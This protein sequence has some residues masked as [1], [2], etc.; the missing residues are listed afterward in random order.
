[1]III[2]HSLIILLVSLS[3]LLLAQP[4][5][6]ANDIV[7]E[8]NIPFKL[9]INP[10]FNGHQWS[11]Q[12]S[13]DIAVGNPDV[14][15][16]GVGIQA[17][18]VPLPES[19]LEFWGYDIRVDAF[20]HYA[21]LGLTENVVFLEAPSDDHR[22]TTFYCNG[23]Q[24]TMFANIYEPIWDDGAN[25]TP[26]N[27]D[28]Y[29]A[30]YFYRT[31]SK[32]KD[33]VKFWEIWNEPDLDNSGT[34]WMPP[35][36]P[37]NWYDN[38][39]DPC[40][41]Q[42]RAPVYEYIRLLRIAYEVIKSVDPDAYI[43][44]GG[45][46][47]ESF[48]DVIL[49]FTDNPDGG[50][51][52]PEYPLTGGAYFD[53]LSFHVYPHINGSLKV[54]DNSISGFAYSRHSDAAVEG[55][56]DF[57]NRFQ[58]ILYQYGYD[59]QTYPEK[60][61]ILTE[62]G[63]PRKQFQDHIGSDAAARNYAIKLQIE[64]Y[65]NNIRQVDIYQLADQA[66]FDD[67]WDWLVMSGLYKQISQIQPYDVIPNEQGVACRTTTA[68]LDG[69]DF[70]EDL[71]AI[72]DLPP[73]IKGGAFVGSSD[74]VFVL[75]TKTDT[76]QSEAAFATY[77]FPVQLNFTSIE[78]R[79]WDYSITN[80]VDEMDPQ[81]V[82]LTGDPVFIKG[83]EVGDLGDSAFD[84]INNVLVKPNPYYDYF[85]LTFLLQNESDILIELYDMRGVKV[86]EYTQADMPQGEH[87]LF[88]EDSEFI[89]QGMYLGKLQVEGKRDIAFKMI[90][91]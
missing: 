12:K 85:E 82:T 26:V 35:T 39:P 73:D 68:I 60:Y 8:Y 40:I 50:A 66:S 72:L 55:T 7:P 16:E 58:D 57:K 75:W 56:I 37:G 5:F 41:I 59:G 64:A 14:G 27:D 49:R 20:Q 78:M 46:G 63:I 33:W 61:F 19:F 38:T 30:L 48:L 76:D 6:T 43:T 9:G 81:N 45:L 25:G 83:I 17:F 89:A 62:T 29:A 15:T 13:A 32:Y 47:Y 70:D 34:G 65:Q 51:V 4:N 79:K 74:T 84:L 71:T 90:R 44:T 88:F 52:T 77:D 2:K 24:S 3:H 69:K 91:L 28:N 87:T 11:D 10:N 42:L 22:D 53:V 86:F 54:W 1:M 23:E 18:R 31:A 80:N 67:G 36:I 21:D